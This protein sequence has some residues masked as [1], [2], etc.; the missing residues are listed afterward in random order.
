MR[1][2]TGR[3]GQRT[4]GTDAE[5]GYRFEAYHPYGDRFRKERLRH[6]VTGPS[7]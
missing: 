4:S 5:L 6:P 3:A 1:R 2:K 7:G